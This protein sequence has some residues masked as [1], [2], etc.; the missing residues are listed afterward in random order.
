MSDENGEVAKANQFLIDTINGLISQ[1]M[2]DDDIVDTLSLYYA[3][4]GLNAEKAHKASL[5]MLAFVKI[6]SIKFQVFTLYVE[7]LG[8]I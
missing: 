1:G 8:A 3:E 6:Q 5:K 2:S 7:I 4:A